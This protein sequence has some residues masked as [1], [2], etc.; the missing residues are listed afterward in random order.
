MSSRT[1]SRYSPSRRLF[2]RAARPCRPCRPPH[3]STPHA[4]LSPSRRRPQAAL[5]MHVPLCPTCR[6]RALPGPC[7]RMRTH[8]RTPT[9]TGTLSSATSDPPAPTHP[10]PLPSPPAVAGRYPRPA[11]ARRSG[12]ASPAP[13]SPRRSAPSL[14]LALAPARRTRTPAL[15]LPG[16]RVPWYQ[17]Q[18]SDGVPLCRRADPQTD[19]HAYMHPCTHAHTHPIHCAHAYGGARARMPVHTFTFSNLAATASVYKDAMTCR[20]ALCNSAPPSLSA[21]AHGQHARNRGGASN[22]SAPSA[23]SGKHSWFPPCVGASAAV[24]HAAVAAVPGRPRCRSPDPRPCP[25]SLPVRHGAVKM[26]PLDMVPSIRDGAA[27]SMLLDTAR[28]FTCSVTGCF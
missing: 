11:A 20:V 3:H 25:R 27:T 16:L 12:T 9:R 4:L 7:C 22:F 19:S 14:A 26:A 24:S 5:A 2:R 10:P 13:G 8:T 21:A 28:A 1:R 17:H 15:P 23:G 6:C 18:T